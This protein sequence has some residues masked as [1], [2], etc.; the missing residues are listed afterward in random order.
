[1]VW[2]ELVADAGA[3]GPEPRKCTYGFCIQDLWVHDWPIHS[4]VN[5]NQPET[6]KL[7]RVLS[8]CVQSPA[9][10]WYKT[11]VGEKFPTRALVE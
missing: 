1:M 3:V 5:R 4:A 8:G 11:E 2:P 10:S 6:T 7:V 9:A